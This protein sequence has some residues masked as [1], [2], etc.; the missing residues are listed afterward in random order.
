MI[1]SVQI[2]ATELVDGFGKLTYSE[3]LKQLQVPTL[4]FCRLWGHMIETYKHFHSYDHDTLPTSFRPRNRPSRSHMYQ[5]HPM[6]PRDG[7]RG[8]HK[9]SFY[10][11]IV[12]LWNNLPSSVPSYF[13]GNLASQ[14]DFIVSNS[15]EH[16]DS[17]K[18][19]EKLVFSDHCPLA[20]SCNVIPT[21]PLET[22][23]ECSKSVF[24]YDH[25]DIN[26]RLKPPLNITRM[27]IATAIT[28]LDEKA[29]EIRE[30]MSQG[31]MENNSLSIK[32]TDGI[33]N[34]CRNSYVKT[35][36]KLPLTGNLV[37]CTSANFK[38]IAQANFA[39]YSQT[40]DEEIKKDY[41]LKWNQ[42]ERLARDASNQE[43]NCNINRSWKNLKGDGKK[44]WDR[45]D[46]NG[47]SEIKPEKQADA[48]EISKYFK[49]IFQSFKTSH[50]PKIDSVKENIENHDTYIPILDDPPTMDE[51]ESAILKIG[52][53][54]SLDG[55]PPDVA[56]ILPASMKEVILQLL[57]EVFFNE[58]PSEWSKQILHA[59]KKDGHTPAD[60]KLRGIAIGLLLCRLYDIIIDER[61]R[62]WLHPNPEQASCA[63]QGCL[64]QLFLLMMLIDYSKEK[65]K[66]LF[67]GFMDYE[68]AYDFVNRA[69]IIND[70][71][72]K[73]CEKPSQTQ[74]R[75]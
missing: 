23:Y 73:G 64:F 22:V 47:K 59:L 38:A 17:F 75:I 10:C 52:T 35:I 11:R 28:L 74:L 72:R 48:A 46:W 67:V 4:A 6:K 56:K 65:Q 13:R 8:I 66:D 2:R 14:N 71:I 9:N 39:A 7:E 55:L 26:K 19:L 62:A 25:Y 27:D 50:H 40:T 37:N 60:P 12:D 61:F 44:M 69:E 54:V 45:I 5:I 33:Y 18:I 16:I 31:R 32:I 58:Y 49:S 41:L 15:I 63:G 42:F 20:V 24:N 30:E 51:L 29:K 21:T 70:L 68:K 53:G 34:A 57:I 3:R 43:L 1:E 36:P